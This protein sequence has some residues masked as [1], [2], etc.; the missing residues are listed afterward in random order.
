MCVKKMIRHYTLTALTTD[1][2]FTSNRLRP[3]AGK[4]IRCDINSV[5]ET[6]YSICMLNA[7]GGCAILQKSILRLV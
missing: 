2:I 6:M 4:F 1:Q 7:A 3:W 5:D